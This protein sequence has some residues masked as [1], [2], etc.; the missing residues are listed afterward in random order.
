[1]LSKAAERCGA[2]RRIAHAIVARLGGTSGRRVVL[3]FML[4]TALCSMW[5][6]NTATT[7]M[8]LPVALAVLERDSSGKLGV[9][10]PLGIAYSASIGGIATPIGTPPNA[11]VFGAGHVRIAD[12]ARYGLVLNLFGAVI[13]TLA[14]WLLLPPV[15]DRG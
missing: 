7:L 3:A 14:C 2:H 5:I 10:L 13:V 4:A 9:P 8:M 15:L 12:M 11:I 6:S 1:M